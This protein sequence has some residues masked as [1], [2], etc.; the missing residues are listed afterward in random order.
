MLTLRELVNRCIDKDKPAWNE[1]VFRLKAIAEKAVRLRLSRHNFP[2]TIEDI[3]DIT[4]AIFL[5]IWEG[6]KL[7]LVKDQEK[8]TAWLA[9][10]A[11]N[12]AIDFIRKAKNLIRQA[13]PV[14]NEDGFEVNV[15][16]TLAAKSNPAD[17]LLTL[18]LTDILDSLINSFEP[19]DRLILKLNLLHSQ[20][21][22]EIAALLRLPQNTVSTIIRRSISKLRESLVRRGYKNF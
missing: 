19:R 4:Q 13:P 18:E 22:K 14:L 7:E 9:M 6:N 8:I 2:H 11:Q 17:E 21:H 1:F 20:S 12:A 15:T 10:V 16:D 5:D 3:K